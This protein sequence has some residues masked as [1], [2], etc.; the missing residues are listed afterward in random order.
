MFEYI[1][2]I[3]KVVPID[4]GEKRLLLLQDYFLG[5]VFWKLYSFPCQSLLLSSMYLMILCNEDMI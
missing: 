3:D 2:G 4:I 5:H 1:F